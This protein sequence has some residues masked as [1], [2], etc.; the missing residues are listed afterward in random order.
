MDWFLY[1]NGR[2]HENINIKQKLKPHKSFFTDKN[3]WNRYI[4]AN[5]SANFVDVRITVLMSKLRK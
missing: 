5:Y 1:D 3:F 2:R 4:S